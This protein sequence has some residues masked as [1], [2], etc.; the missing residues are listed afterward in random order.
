MIL[1]NFMPSP[2]IWGGF[3]AKSIQPWAQKTLLVGFLFILW[4]KNKWIVL[5]SF[6]IYG[7]TT[8]CTLNA[9]TKSPMYVA[10]PLLSKDKIFTFGTWRLSLSISIRRLMIQIGRK[11]ILS[12]PL[13][14]LC[15]FFTKVISIW[16]LC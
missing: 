2:P 16:S 1:T 11:G 6:L 9:S 5:N 12:P 14:E 10:L 3:G 8:T 15:S 7:P 13:K 4:K